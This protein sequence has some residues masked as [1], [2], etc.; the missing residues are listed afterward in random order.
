MAT[1]TG[2]RGQRTGGLRLGRG[3]GSYLFNFSWEIIFYCHS[4]YRVHFVFSG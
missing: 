2:L 1:R 4:R 3:W